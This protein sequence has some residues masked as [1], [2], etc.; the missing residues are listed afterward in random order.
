MS[1]ENKR[2]TIAVGA[3]CVVGWGFAYLATNVYRDYAFGLFV[4]LPTVMAATATM[5]EGYKNPRA[6]KHFRNTAF[7]SFVIFC[8]GLLTFAWD[9]I[10]CMVMAAPVGILFTWIGYRIGYAVVKSSLNP[11]IP[12][13]MVLLVV[14]V[15]SLMA[16]ENVKQR[17][18]KQF[19][20]LINQLNLEVIKAK[21]IK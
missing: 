12:T 9:G 3:T 4:W 16:F 2:Q 18:V 15:P 21:T 1:T 6:K 13:A 11:N 5:V 10:I 19:N 7:L 14:S 20:L 17:E 8:A